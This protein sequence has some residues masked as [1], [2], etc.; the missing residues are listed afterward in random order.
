VLRYERDDFAARF[1]LSHA[2]DKFEDSERITSDLAEVL[3]TQN[4]LDGDLKLRLS[5][6]TELSGNASNLDYPTSYVFGADYRI[7]DDIDLVA[8]YEDASGEDLDATMTRL[9]VR[10]T[11][12]SR[13]Q[14]NSFLTNETTEFGPRLFA[15][16]GLIQG[17][18]LNENWIIDV[19]VDHADTLVDS[20]ARQF[21]PDRE[22]SSGSLNEDFTAAYAGAMYTS[23][24]WSAN[25]RLETRNSDSEDRVSILMGWYRQPSLGH[26]LSAGLT[27]FQADS[28][29]GNEL[30][31]ANLRL[32]WAYRLADNEWSFLDR[33]DLVYDE[34]N[35]ATDELKSWRL[36]NNFNANRRI[37][38]VAQLSLQYAFKYVRSE[39]DGDGYTGYTDLIGI[40]YRRALSDRWDTGVNTSI[41]HS[42][43]SEVLDYG[44]GLD[45][46]YNIGRNMWLTLGYNIFGFDDKDFE[47][48]RYTAAG[49]Y[50]RFSIKADQRL[51][52]NIAGQ[53]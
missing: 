33:I 26:G 28:A 12:W 22:L 5:G 39:F 41:Y 44:I 32:G 37:S 11:P 53:R 36:I 27:M 2:E 4:M 7:I 34:A 45:V 47:R 30:N 13:A 16:V 40:D 3:L 31:Q 9:G 48:A 52:K 49:P 51:L 46:G 15:N 17:F 50:L 14:I 19:G 10:A 21:D 18:Q 38:A 29:L 1:G 35:A 23:D 20:D 42:Y 6:S 43:G 24:L 25:A 8:E